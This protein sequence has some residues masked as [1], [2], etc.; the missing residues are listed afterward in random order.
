[1]TLARERSGREGGKSNA[2]INTVSLWALLLHSA[3]HVVQLFSYIN[4]IPNSL[5]YSLLTTTYFKNKD[6]KPAFSPSYVTT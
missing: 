3:T 1:M 2:E 5:L 6:F 4:V